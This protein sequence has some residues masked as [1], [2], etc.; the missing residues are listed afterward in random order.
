MRFVHTLNNTA[1]ASTRTI[2]A[3]PENHQQKDGTILCPRRSAPSSADARCW[4]VQSGSSYEM[5]GA[6]TG[7]A[8]RSARIARKSRA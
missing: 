1:L 8:R 5:G 2:M 6:L 4:G 3:L 7:L